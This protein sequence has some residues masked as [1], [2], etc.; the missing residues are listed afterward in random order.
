MSTLS[1]EMEMKIT[2]VVTEVDEADMD[3][4]EK[5]FLYEKI[6][7]AKACANGSTD[8]IDDMSKVL[9]H[10]TLHQVKTEVRLPVKITKIVREE[11]A[12]TE[13][14][15]IAGVK[16]IINDSIQSHAKECWAKMVEIKNQ[17][18]KDDRAACTACRGEAGT[19]DGTE[20]T[21]EKKS[22]SWAV[23]WFRDMAKESPIITA[24]ILI[25]FIEKVGFEPL[26]SLGMK[27][28][29]F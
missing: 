29:G 20:A 15:I 25:I 18:L 14:K 6:L 3:F 27:L 17:E 2:N 23:K 28:F 26:I 12:E 9:L 1:D 22:S 21:E 4:D 16:T 19:G 11:L 7:Q 24:V 8:K 13:K 10:S 5:T